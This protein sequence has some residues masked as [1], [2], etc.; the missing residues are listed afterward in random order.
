[1]G[2]KLSKQ[3]GMVRRTV[4]WRSVISRGCLVDTAKFPLV[5]RRV[6]NDKSIYT[7][8]VRTPF[9]GP[10][11]EHAVGRSTSMVADTAAVDNVTARTTG[12]TNR[13]VPALVLPIL[14]VRAMQLPT[15]VR[16]P[17]VRSVQLCGV[18]QVVA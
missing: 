9:Q 18:T 15:V 6:A 2:V 17:P 14:D 16:V 13:V 5:A 10:S 12:E 3:A 7:P 4:L 11:V 8:S 1:M